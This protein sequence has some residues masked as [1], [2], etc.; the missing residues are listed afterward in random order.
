MGLNR[1]GLYITHLSLIA[2]QRAF[3]GGHPQ[4]SRARVVGAFIEDPLR[5]G[6]AA[7]AGWRRERGAWV[8]GVC[9][10]GSR[11]QERAV[12]TVQIV[13]RLRR[14]KE[15]PCPALLETSSGPSCPLRFFGVR[16]DCGNFA[17]PSDAGWLPPRCG[18]I[19][20]QDHLRYAVPLRHPAAALPSLL[21]HVG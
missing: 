21:A 12:T 9:E 17:V 15:S 6:W 8:D 20:L 14:M 2:G 13:A 16:R 1:S 18:R 11:A 19:T 7:H 5:R 10:R 4:R 3:F